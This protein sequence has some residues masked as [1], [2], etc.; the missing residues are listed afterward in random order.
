MSIRQ[1]IENKKF[2]GICQQLLTTFQ[3]LEKITVEDMFFQYNILESLKKLN[4]KSKSFRVY[5]TFNVFQAK[6]LIV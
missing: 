4:I 3:N 1:V 5:K 2:F 6:P